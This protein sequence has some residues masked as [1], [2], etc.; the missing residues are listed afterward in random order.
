MMGDVEGHKIISCYEYMKFVNNP[1]RSVRDIQ[2][3][4]LCYGTRRDKKVLRDSMGRDIKD[5]MILI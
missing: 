2:V 5:N 3:L 4:K 1:F